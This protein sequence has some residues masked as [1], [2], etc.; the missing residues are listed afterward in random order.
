MSSAKGLIGIGLGLLTG[1]LAFAAV[2]ALGLASL[3]PIAAGLVFSVTASMVMGQGSDKQEAANS[4]NGAEDLT[5]NT[6]TEAR[7]IPVTFGK[8][9]IGGNIV[10]YDKS[11]FK[12]KPIYQED[13]VETE[14]GKGFG[15]GAA[16]GPEGQ[17]AIIGY[18]YFLS[19]DVGYCVGPVDEISGLVLQ[20]TEKNLLSDN[21]DKEGAQTTTPI[22]FNDST[23]RVQRDISDGDS[24]EGNARFYSGAHNQNRYSNDHYNE[25]HENHR[26]VCFIHFRETKMGRAPSP[27]SMMI[28]VTRLP[29]VLDANGDTIAGFPVRG[30]TSSGDHA[31]DHAN[32]AAAMWEILTNDLWGAGIP[33]DQ[34]DVESFKAA[35]VFFASKKIGLSFVLS[36]QDRMSEAINFIRDHVQ[37]VLIWNGEKVKMVVLMDRTGAYNPIHRITRDQVVDPVF[38][39]PTWPSTV[40]EIR[41]TFINRRAKHR[42]QTVVVQDL[43]S[44]EAVG[45]IQSRSYD[46]PGLPTRAIATRQAR[47][48]LNESAYPQASLSFRMNRILS[49]L[50][51]GSF[52]IFV[53]P[54]WTNGEAITF[55]RVTEIRDNQT[56][57]GDLEVQLI[58]DTYAVPY[59]G[60]EEDF[61][62]PEAPFEDGDDV[63]DEDVSTGDDHGTEVTGEFGPGIVWEPPSTMTGGERQAI[64]A[65]QRRSGYT[66]YATWAWEAAGGSPRNLPS[67]APWAVFC[68]LDGAV[69]I[70]RR[71][72]RTLEIL[73]DLEWPD[74]IETVLESATYLET[75]ADHYSDLTATRVSLLL[76]GNEV[77]RVGWATEPSTGKVAFAGL[78][79]GCFGTDV[80]AHAD[81]DVAVFLPVLDVGYTWSPTAIPLNEDTT[82]YADQVTLRGSTVD[83]TQITFTGPEGTG[84]FTGRSIRPPAP[85]PIDATD[86]AGDWTAR[87]RIR[88]FGLGAGTGATLVEDLNQIIGA[89]PPG[90]AFYVVGYTAGDAVVAGATYTLQTTFA[91]TPADMPAA[92]GIGRFEFLPGTGD[93]GTCILEL[94][95]TP[96]GTVAKFK[97]WT[98]QNGALSETPYT[99]DP[100]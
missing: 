95:A 61:L 8:V 27:P 80:Q 42:T 92:L 4:R 40:N 81:G 87:F 37:T 17:D 77:M 54:D 51:A 20:P 97:I 63:E 75:A 85:W 68:V 46:L 11:R 13:V 56:D 59:E 71:T 43:G 1:G 53:W 50:E 98:V 86:A 5:I 14:G 58:E 74:D 99:L 24:I 93:A 48:I 25:D 65:M 22:T 44:I 47:R 70:T 78:L 29:R 38:S 10:R 26:N 72:A 89:I 12:S 21:P 100:S 83:D 90:F 23:T 2:G 84:D 96:T 66:A 52:V 94:E 30:S 34:L 41:I 64:V 60:E 88:T 62:E 28:E 9:K 31:Y 33:H 57:S 55:W 69:P 7:P 16:G 79:R 82:F 91:T 6:A 35:A 32:P 15:G 49:G 19:W 73:A 18:D 39:R 45:R 36:S 76:I 67:V 3:A